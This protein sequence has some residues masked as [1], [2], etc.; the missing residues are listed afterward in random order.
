MPESF[1]RL[2]PCGWENERELITQD[3]PAFNFNQGLLIRLR[4]TPNPCGRASVWPQP[5][6]EP[7]WGP[8][9]AP[10]AETK[11]SQPLLKRLNILPENQID[12]YS[13]QAGRNVDLLGG[14]VLAPLP[15]AIFVLPKCR[16][17]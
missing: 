5:S 10:L 7:G 14:E 6:D 12:W 16:K 13:A 8:G 4:K 3:L 15:L 17:S 9:A 2:V 1:A 11:R